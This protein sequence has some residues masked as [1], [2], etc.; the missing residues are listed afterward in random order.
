MSPTPRNGANSVGARPRT[1]AAHAAHSCDAGICRNALPGDCTAGVARRVAKRTVD[2]G[3]PPSQGSIYTLGPADP[4]LHL[5]RKPL[6]LHGPR[7]PLQSPRQA[8]LPPLPIQ[9]AHM[10]RRFV[11]G[12][13]V[14]G[15]PTRHFSGSVGCRRTSWS[16]RR[17]W[18]G[19]TVA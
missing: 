17:R 3:G 16:R 5:H 4:D 8:A 15:R 2:S 19:C 12:S 6:T 9:A 10:L 18:S 13:P 14:I 7:N 1:Q 11:D